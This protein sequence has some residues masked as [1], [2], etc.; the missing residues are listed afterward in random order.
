MRDVITLIIHAGQYFE[1]GTNWVKIADALEPAV[2]QSAL[3]KAAEDAPPQTTTTAIPIDEI[4]RAVAEKFQKQ[5]LSPFL[6][7]EIPEKIQY[8]LLSLRCTALKS[9]ILLI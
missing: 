1:L 2:Y 4:A 5:P 3:M 6:T 7:K 9:V 8:I